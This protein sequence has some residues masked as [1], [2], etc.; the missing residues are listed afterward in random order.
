MLIDL[1]P[2]DFFNILKNNL[3]LS[4]LQEIR[5][6]QNKPIILCYRGKLCYIS[7]NGVSLDK[8]HAVYATNGLIEH[9]IQVATNESLYSAN[10]QIKQG[11]ITC[12]DGIRIGLCGELVFDGQI[13]KTIKNFSSLNIRVPHEVRNCSLNFLP[14]LFDNNE[15]RNTLIISPPGAGKTTFIRDFC[16]QISKQQNVIKNILVLDERSE[17]ATQVDSSIDIGEFCDVLRNCT[18]DYGFLQGIRSMKPDLIVT[19][20]L[21]GIKDSKAVENASACGV[22]IMASIHASDIYDLKNKSE[23]SELLSKKIFKRFIVLSNR[24]GPGTSEGVFDENFRC[25]WL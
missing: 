1:L 6:R 8:E 21:A 9:I 15:F 5:I 20:E 3:N 13:L 12:T 17:I 7:K 22:N 25:L 10:E 2:Q 11:F 14:F 18:K 23:F 24:N 4:Y 16:Y 19:D